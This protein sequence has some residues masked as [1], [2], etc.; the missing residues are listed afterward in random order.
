MDALANYSSSS[1]SSD[2]DDDESIQDSQKL[3]KATALSVSSV[4]DQGTERPLKKLKP[5]TIID[6]KNENETQN[7]LPPPII[8]VSSSSNDDGTIQSNAFQQ[9]I[10]MPENYLQNEQLMQPPILLSK[11]LSNKLSTL[12]TKSKSSFAEHIKSQKEFGNP[13]LFPSIIEHFQIQW[14]GTNIPGKKFQRFE[15]IEKLSSK[16]EQIRMSSQHLPN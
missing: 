9:L 6:D 1:S 15:Y 4:E 13:H 5:S 14:R 7:L 16:E 11:H 10:C 12:Q 3:S 2:N 8:S